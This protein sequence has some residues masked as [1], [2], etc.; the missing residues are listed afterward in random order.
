MKFNFVPNPN[1]KYCREE[2]QFQVAQIC[3]EALMF[4]EL[5]FRLLDNSYVLD[6]VNLGVEEDTLSIFLKNEKIAE[7]KIEDVG[8]IFISREELIEYY[9]PK[10]IP[11]QFFP[12]KGEFEYV[13]DEEWYERRDRR[14]RVRVEDTV[15]QEIVFAPP[16]SLPEL[17]LSYALLEG[18]R[19]R[20]SNRL[21][22]GRDYIP[23]KCA[24][25]ELSYISSIPEVEQFERI[26]VR[27]DKLSR[28]VSNRLAKKELKFLPE[29]SLH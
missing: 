24:Y 26:N 27:L 16:A 6:M 12:S 11:Q 14:L 8:F 19:V 23:H 13:V 22:E 5:I 20:I 3:S 2:V 28:L 29:A 25:L 21:E 7:G 15:Y 4:E 18:A 1:P 17:V 10:L 9:R